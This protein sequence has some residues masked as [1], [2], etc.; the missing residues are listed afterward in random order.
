MEQKDEKTNPEKKGTAKS[1]DACE[2]K[3][4]EEKKDC[5]DNCMHCGAHCIYL[6]K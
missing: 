1:R 4:E 3:K 5:R 2:N 6:K